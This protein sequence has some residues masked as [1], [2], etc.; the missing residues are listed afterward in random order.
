M[1]TAAT[2]KTKLPTELTIDLT[3]PVTVA[4]AEVS[5]LKMRFPTVKDKEMADR[6]HPEDAGEAEKF[7]LAQ[8][9]GL[10]PDD[11]SA[12]HLG[13]YRSLQIALGK[14]MGVRLQ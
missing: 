4:G 5:S 11:L 8:M 1:S 7:M 10:A 13:D 12:M 14:F 3:V 2:K 6:A 9:T